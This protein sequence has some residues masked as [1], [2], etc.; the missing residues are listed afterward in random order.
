MKCTQQKLQDS[1]VTLDVAFKTT[2]STK[3][4]MRAPIKNLEILYREKYGI[5]HM[6]NL[7]PQGIY[8]H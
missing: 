7:S 6:E 2:F 5:N 1:D 4:F 8:S 3:T